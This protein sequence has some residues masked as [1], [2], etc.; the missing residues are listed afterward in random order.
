MNL[1][2][3]A[4]TFVGAMTIAVSSFAAIK[5]VDQCPDVAAIQ[6]QGISMVLPLD[7]D[8]YIG[9]ETSNYQ[10]DSEWAF[11]IGPVATDDYDAAIGLANDALKN[12]SGSP[13]PEEEGI[14]FCEYNTGSDELA[15]IA[16]S[17]EDML[18]TQKVKHF[19]HKK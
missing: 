8:L 19:F 3:K 15:A 6:A 16:V 11:L 5:A 7:F 14:I 17:A 2:S 9:M 18:S 1:L 13:I 10:T 4:V 12:I